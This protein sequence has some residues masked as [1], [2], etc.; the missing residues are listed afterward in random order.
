MKKI[1]ALAALC[2]L[3]SFAQ[4]QERFPILAPQQRTPEQAHVLQALLAGP[5][6]GG[7]PGP[8]AAKGLIRGQS[9][10]GLRSPDLG[11]RLQKEGQYSRY[12]S[13]NPLRLDQSAFL[14]TAGHW[15]SQY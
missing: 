6:G 1:L 9:N 11:E 8:E 3:N 13:S 4:A 10:V 12:N 15:N 2:S 14:S 7:Q 5:R